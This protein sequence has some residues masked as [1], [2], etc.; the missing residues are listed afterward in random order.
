VSDKF[1]NAVAEI[2][3]EGA[4]IKQV[5]IG[6]QPFSLKQLPEGSDDPLSLFW[7]RR[8]VS[9]AQVVLVVRLGSEGFQGADHGLL[10]RKKDAAQRSKLIDAASLAIQ[11]GA[12]LV[13]LQRDGLDPIEPIS[14]QHTEVVIVLE[15]LLDGFVPMD[16][17]A[18]DIED[19]YG[20]LHVWMYTAG[21]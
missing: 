2:N 3:Q 7:H 8:K 1:I 9:H 16:G 13:E 21:S 11:E 15:N 5:D 20:N 12:G 19:S 4:V 18:H 10:L 17:C 6:N 14:L